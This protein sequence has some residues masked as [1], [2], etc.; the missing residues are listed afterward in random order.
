MRYLRGNGFGDD[1]IQWASCTS[2]YNN[3]FIGV[4]DPGYP[5]GQHQ[6]GIQT[7]GPYIALYGNY[8]QNMQ[9]YPIYGDCFGP[10]AHWRIY[11]NIMYQPDTANSQAVGLGCDG[12]PCTQSDIIVSNNTV[13]SSDHCIFI[14]QGTPGTV[15]SSY[16]VN[17][18]CYNSDNQVSTATQSNNTTSTNGIVFVNPASDWHLQASATAAIGTG[19]SPSYLTSVYTT[20]KDGTQRTDPWSIGAYTFGTSSKPAAPTGLTA[21]VH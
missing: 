21:T 5:G 9:N 2:I 19:I 4:Y 10:T 16:V 17:N 3:Q 15:S 1:G 7:G 8:Y 13:V 12:T 14:N 20:D 6:D 18:L 11:N